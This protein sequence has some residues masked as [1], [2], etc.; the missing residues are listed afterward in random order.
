MEDNLSLALHWKETFELNNCEVVLSHTGDEAAAHLDNESFDLVVTDLVEP[1]Q[2]G[3]LHVLTKL[4][5]MGRKAPPAIVAT[6]SNQAAL[7]NAHIDIVLDQAARLGASASLQKPFHSAEL[8]LL[9][10]DVWAANNDVLMV[11]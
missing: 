11:A 1:R 5:T 2:K 6:G 9:A 8:M 7:G 10:Q 3:G 4:F